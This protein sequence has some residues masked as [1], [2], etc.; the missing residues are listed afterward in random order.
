MLKKSIFFLFFVFLVCCKSLPDKDDAK[1]NN[2]NKNEK[3]VLDKKQK[4]INEKEKFTLEFVD[5]FCDITDAKETVSGIFDLTYSYNFNFRYGKEFKV[6]YK[7]FDEDNVEILSKEVF[8]KKKKSDIYSIEGSFSD[9]LSHKILRYSFIAFLDN[10]TEEYGGEFINPT[11][12]YIEKFSFGPIVSEYKNNKLE[13][14]SS[15]EIDIKNVEKI[16]WIRFIPPS[17]NYFWEINYSFFDDR[18]ISNSTITDKKNS[19]YFENGVYILQVN[20]GE[21]G[22]IQKNFELVDIL[23]NSNG[24]N[25]GLSIAEETANDKNKLK[26]DIPQ[27]ENIE[28][29]DIEIFD[30]NTKQ[31]LGAASFLSPPKEIDKKELFKS[32]KNEYG[33]EVK[34]KYNK[35]YFYKIFLYSKEVNKVRYISISNERQLT[36]FGF[37]FM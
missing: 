3:I 22:L 21:K 1:K 15:L 27:F 31:K 35:K 10:K 29:M 9:P 2:E 13:T 28:T 6:F 11:A 8:A 26:L 14:S 25:Y 17:Q 23:G 34:L 24:K 19:H 12:S 7:I 30:S 32:F 33:D 18:V 37:S 20:F 16:K 4:E 36:F 5:F